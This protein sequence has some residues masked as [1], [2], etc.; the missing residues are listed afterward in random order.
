M[1]HYLPDPSVTTTQGVLQ[2]NTV[3]LYLANKQ[4][5]PRSV[6]TYWYFTVS[7][8]VNGE[9]SNSKV[10]H[11]VSLIFHEGDQV[12]YP[13][14]DHNETTEWTQHNK[15]FEKVLTTLE[16]QYLTSGDEIT[17]NVSVT[18]EKS[19]KVTA[20]V[21]DSVDSYKCFTS[22][23]NINATA[24]GYVKTHTI[25]ETAPFRFSPT[26][27]SYY[28]VVLVSDN[29]VT[30]DYMHQ[31]FFHFYNLTDYDTVDSQS[32]DID[33]NT[34]EC[35]FTLEGREGCLFAYGKINGTENELAYVPLSIQVEHN[36]WNFP[37]LCC[38]AVGAALLILTFSIVLLKFG[39]NYIIRH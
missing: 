5:L 1:F 6:N 9:N 15:T 14:A 16:Y 35:S 3:P 27:P 4:E 22:G 24:C 17:L 33:Y 12:C 26:V 13:L 38:L 36:I 20:Y 32:C 39:C 30:V 23:Q 25:V 2:G 19:N 21:L 37:G 29:K 31:V 8:K 11:R 34:R 7:V 28:F 10:T 18:G